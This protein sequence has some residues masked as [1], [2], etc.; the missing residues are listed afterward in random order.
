[1]V[2]THVCHRDSP[3]RK[4]VS[5][6]EGKHAEDVVVL[7]DGIISVEG[8]EQLTSLPFRW[9]SEGGHTVSRFAKF[10]SLFLKHASVGLRLWDRYFDGTSQEP[11]ARV[12]TI[13]E[14]EDITAVV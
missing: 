14:A 8:G 6:Q 3:L 9:M 10:R 12:M 5:I 11:R 4:A 2:E 1:M 13:S 7:K